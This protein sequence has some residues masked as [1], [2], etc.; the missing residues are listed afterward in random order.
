M[1]RNNF[2]IRVLIVDDSDFMRNTLS[3]MLMKFPDVQVVGTAK[4]GMD[5]IEQIKRSPPDVMTLDVDMPGM[6]GLDVLD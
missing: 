1:R 5:A 2:P 6:N 3:T 4:N